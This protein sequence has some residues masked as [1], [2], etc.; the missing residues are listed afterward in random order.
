MGKSGFTDTVRKTVLIDA[1]PKK[2][3]KIISKITNLWWVAGVAKTSYLAG[4]SSKFGAGRV[5]ST[6]AGSEIVEVITGWNVNEYISYVALS[7]LDISAYHATISLEQKTKKTRIIWESV[8][9]DKDENK[10]EIFKKEIA[11]FY[12]KSLNT[13]RVRF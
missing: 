2:V 7:G 4:P 3:W 8:F 10:V 6:D 9:A 11:K 1:P 5:I 13:L 12:A